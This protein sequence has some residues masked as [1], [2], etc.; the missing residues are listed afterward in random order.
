MFSSLR[1]F[2]LDAWDWILGRKYP[3]QELVESLRERSRLFPA[4]LKTSQ[5]EPVL[6]AKKKP[7]TALVKVD[8][9]PPLKG[10]EGFARKDPGFTQLVRQPS[11]QGMWEREVIRAIEGS[12]EIEDPRAPSEAD[13]RSPVQQLERVQQAEAWHD[14]H[15]S[16]SVV[17]SR[18]VVSHEEF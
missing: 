8:L 6:A 5:M 1:E 10:L 7:E 11:M 3:R 12:R 13:P 17:I 4:H 9:P 14:T 18:R 15:P 2:T 16:D